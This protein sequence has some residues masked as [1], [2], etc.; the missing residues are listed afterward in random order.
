MRAIQFSNQNKDILSLLGLYR[1]RISMPH[2]HLYFIVTYGTSHAFVVEL[3]FSCHF[4]GFLLQRSAER[5]TRWQCREQ[6]RI[7]SLKFKKE[8]KKEKGRKE[9]IYIHFK[10]WSI[11]KWNI[12]GSVAL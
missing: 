1:K 12:H 9:V 7:Y 5:L 4:E 11:L 6:G 2:S 10:G 3:L 8:R